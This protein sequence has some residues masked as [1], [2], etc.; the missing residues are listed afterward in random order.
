[1]P[2]GPGERFCFPDGGT[3]LGT[4]DALPVDDLR[5]RRFPG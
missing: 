3:E 1:M 5:L 4:C 2:G